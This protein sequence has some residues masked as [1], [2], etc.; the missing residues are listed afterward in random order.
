MVRR[1][2]DLPPLTALAVFEACARHSSF[3]LAAAELNVTPGAVSR[4]I[5]AIEED[6]GVPLFARRARGVTPTP[7]GEELYA[8]LATG[9]S[10]ASDVIR[11]IRRGDKSRN[12]II[13]CSDV[14]ATMWLIPRMPDFWRNVGDVTVDHLISDDVRTFRRAEVELRIRHGL[15]A[16][17]DETAEFL[18]RDCLYP[19]CSPRFAEVHSDAT[20]QAL[21]RLPL[22]DV[23]WIDPDWMGWDELLLRA[24]IRQH[25]ANIRRLGK[26][27]VALQAAMADQGVVIG[28]HRM[29]QPL[30]ERG[31]LVRFTDLL[32]PSPG[33]YY[34]TWNTNRDLSAAAIVLRDW[35]RRVAEGEREAAAPGDARLP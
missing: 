3:K 24:G 26:F 19:V 2:Y 14:F 12:V 23:N 16:W 8:V 31:Q 29:V 20:S 4:Q 21:P 22:I 28:W 6:L 10:R 18:F 15:G 35:I 11:S 32:V 1:F 7:A 27:S 34:L 13:A 30:V 17:I 5:K 9:F 33:A 25:A